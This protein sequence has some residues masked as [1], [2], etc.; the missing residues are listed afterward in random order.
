MLVV[1]PPETTWI[2][3]VRQTIDIV[4]HNKAAIVT[5]TFREP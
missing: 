1:A 2:S 5:Y 3:Y 4:Q